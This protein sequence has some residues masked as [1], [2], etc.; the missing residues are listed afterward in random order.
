M[1]KCRK[2][3]FPFALLLISGFILIPSSTL[4]GEELTEPITPTL[5]PDIKIRIKD[6]FIYTITIKN[7]EI[8]KYYPITWIVEGLVEGQQITRTDIH[9]AYLSDLNTA[10][11]I[12]DYEKYPNKGREFTYNQVEYTDEI[13]LSPYNVKL[14]AIM[15][16]IHCVIDTQDYTFGPV[17]IDIVVVEEEK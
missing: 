11:G 12:N 16:V 5:N 8:G 4:R 10:E 15:L 3:I 6:D 14:P 9:W 17:P 1:K 13:Y 7:N 2:L